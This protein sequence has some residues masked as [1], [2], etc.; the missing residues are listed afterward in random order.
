[1]QRTTGGL[2]CTSQQALWGCASFRVTSSFRRGGAG[3]RARL[4]PLLDLGE[5][6]PLGRVSAVRNGGRAPDAHDLAGL[7][8]GR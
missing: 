1:M 7:E 2:D 3:L 4:R 5:E 8:G 6:R